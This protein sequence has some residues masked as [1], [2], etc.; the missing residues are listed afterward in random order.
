ML[1]I[2]EGSHVSFIGRSFEFPIMSLDVSLY[3]V[4]SVIAFCCDL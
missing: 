3:E 1:N 2:P 4:Q